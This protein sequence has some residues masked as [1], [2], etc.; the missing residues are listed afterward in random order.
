MNPSA[1]RNRRR[2]AA[3]AAAAAVVGVASAAFAWGMVAH[4]IVTRQ[5]TRL[6]PSALR[7]FFA[8]NEKNL[9][10]FSNEP[11]AKAEIDPAER[12]NHFLDLDAFDQPPFAN[13]P[14]DEKAFVEKYGKD[15]E[16]DGR[17]PWA[18]GDSYRALV[19]AFAD[20]DYDAILKSAGYVAHY[21]ADSTMPLH[22][23]KNY[24]GQDSGN[25]IFEGGALD[26]H[27]HVRFEIGMIETYRQTVEARVAEKLAKA[28]KVTDPA[29]E[30]FVLLA[31]SYNF[32]EPILAADREF[33]KEGQPVTPQYYAGM[34]GRVGGL[35]VKQMAL[36]ATEVASYWQ[37][38]W[39]EAGSPNLVAGE[40]V[41]QTKPLTLE[42]AMAQKAAEAPREE[43]AAPG[44]EKAAEPTQEK[45]APSAEEKPGGA[46][47]GAAV[48][49]GQENAK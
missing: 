6:L 25:V 44:Q 30:S 19:K 29:G 42:A 49:G 1:S 13:V 36:A 47:E 37:S 5:A 26:R 33:L 14:L 10:L 15:A 34:Y 28:H 12:P 9:V 48:G 38:A 23:T 24:K 21:V 45:T 41:L 46:G 8:A 11:D 3:I 18:A 32:I 27:V 16:K 43:A 22:A 35:A 40:V 4:A 20:R 39:E 2:L 7:P 31:V 17:L